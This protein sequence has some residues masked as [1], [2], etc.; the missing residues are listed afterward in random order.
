MSTLD[1]TR[2]IFH[3]FVSNTENKV[4]S[5]FQTKTRMIDTPLPAPRGRTA[6]QA[7]GHQWASPGT[8]HFISD[9][10]MQKVTVQ[11]QTII[12][13]KSEAMMKFVSL[14]KKINFSTLTRWSTKKIVS[15]KSALWSR[16]HNCHNLVT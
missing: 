3:S 12:L 13:L 8:E 5:S 6:I 15:V 10:S 4:F 14:I 16:P 2:I 11:Y 9:L 7:R 1:F